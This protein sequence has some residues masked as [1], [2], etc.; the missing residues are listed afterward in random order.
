FL[1]PLAARRRG[2]IWS[3][4]SDGGPRAAMIATRD[5]APD[6]PSADVRAGSTCAFARAGQA[7]SVT[8]PR[9]VLSAGRA[10][11]LLAQAHCRQPGLSP[12]TGLSAGCSVDLSVGLSVGVHNC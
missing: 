7:V 12:S 10:V 6:G 8:K 4:P 1:A 5:L 2:L 3:V 9:P 11:F